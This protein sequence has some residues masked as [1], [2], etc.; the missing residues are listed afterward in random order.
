MNGN[1]L[2]GPQFNH[3]PFFQKAGVIKIETR[4]NRKVGVE[5]YGFLDPK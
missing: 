4:F 1:P 5:K 2:G 3:V